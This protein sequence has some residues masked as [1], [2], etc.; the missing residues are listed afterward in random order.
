MPAGAGSMSLATLE[1]DAGSGIAWISINRP[2]VLNA[3]DIPLARALSDC[4]LPLADDPRVRCVVLRGSGPAFMAGGDVGRFAEDF[5]KAEA[6]VD[7]LLGVLNPVIEAL[8]RI[9]APVLAA[10]HGAVAGAGLAFVSAC[11]IVVAA[12]TT[13]FL[14]AYDRVGAAPDCGATYFLPKIL[15]ERR[16]AQFFMLSETLSAAEAKELGLVNFLVPDDALPARVDEL[17]RQLAAGP[18]RAYGHY[19]RL[20]QDSFSSS[21]GDQLEAERKAFRAATRTMDFREGVGAFLAKRR[22]Q[23]KGQ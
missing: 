14:M 20:V 21:L 10:V 8:R 2:Q 18:T 6:V 9:D 12:A 5:G 11:D 19:K 13:K 23:F 4:I 7:E 17:A 1:F 3:L 15:G 22:A 16:A